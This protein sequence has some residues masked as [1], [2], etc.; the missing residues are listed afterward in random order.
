[1]G[2]KIMIDSA[3]DISQAEADKMGLIFMP[4]EIRFDDEEYLD[5]VNLTPAEFYNKLTVAKSL[6][7]TSLINQFRFEE[8]FENA[9][10]NGDEVICITISSK[11]SGTYQSACDASSKFNGKVFVIDSL[12][13]CIGERLLCQYALRLTMENKSAKEIANELNRAKKKIN[14]MAM[15]DTLK[16]LKMGGRISA[17]TAF[18]GGLLSIKPV[19]AVIEGEVKLIGKAMGSKKGNNLLNQ[20]VD[21]KGGIDFSMPYGVIWSG[22]DKSMLEIYVKDSAHL[23]KDYTD[24][25]PEYIVGSTIGTHIGPG[26]VGVAFFEK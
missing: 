3:S 16:Y 12:N 10:K 9:T 7:K 17:T 5:G 26:A 8:A 11:L 24:H 2:I 13:A 25:V 21:K 22:N 18:I 15:L 1:M 20:L 6:P 19:I 14:V 23:W 4:M